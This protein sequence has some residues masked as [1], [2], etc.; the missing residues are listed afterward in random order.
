MYNSMLEDCLR[1]F[2]EKCEGTDSVPK[3]IFRLCLKLPN[4]YVKTKIFL[5]PQG[6][7]SWKGPLDPSKG[8]PFLGQW[9]C[10]GKYQLLFYHLLLF[11]IILVIAQWSNLI[12][13]AQ[14]LIFILSLSH[15]CG[16]TMSC[17]IFVT[18]WFLSTKL[19]QI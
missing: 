16:Q 4:I 11:F 1:V 9:F 15:R 2:L 7:I 8:S 12:V 5:L 13:A 10:P 3:I 19:S 18:Q 14:Q 6:K 17:Q